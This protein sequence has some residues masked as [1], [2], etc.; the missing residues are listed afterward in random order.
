MEPSWDKSETTKAQEKVNENE[1]VRQQI[2]DY[3]NDKTGND[4]DQQIKNN[5]VRRCRIREEYLQWLS[6]VIDKSK[7]WLGTSR[8]IYL[9][10]WNLFRNR[11]VTT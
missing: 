10:H 9:A 3:L 11:L 5:Q 4:T 1:D 2:I 6:S 7:V 8:E